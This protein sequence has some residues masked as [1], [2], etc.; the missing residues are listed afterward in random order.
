MILGSNQHYQT[1]PPLA[2]GFRQPGESLKTQ[3]WLPSHRHPLA[4][5]RIF[6]KKVKMTMWKSMRM[7]GRRGNL[8]TGR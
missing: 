2:I 8:Q 3:G 5:P 1:T 6:L 4:H 7:I